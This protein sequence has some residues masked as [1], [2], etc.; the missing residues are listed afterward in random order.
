M[1]THTENQ[2]DILTS[3]TITSINDGIYTV[4]KIVGHYISDGKIKYLVKWANFDTT[5]NTWEPIESFADR[6]FVEKYNQRHNIQMVKSNET[7][8][9]DSAE[10]MHLKCARNETILYHRLRGGFYE[11]KVK[12]GASARVRWKKIQQFA[13]RQIVENYNKMNCIGIYSMR[14]PIRIVAENRNENDE[15]IVLIERQRIKS[16]E[17]VTM[18]WMIN[19]YPEIVNEY[20]DK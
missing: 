19:K 20:L 2:F 11:Y 12:C 3:N 4:E 13:N 5:H 6:E 10:K 18:E 15:I 16:M 14:R 1:T 17:Y 9:D 8:A 7:D